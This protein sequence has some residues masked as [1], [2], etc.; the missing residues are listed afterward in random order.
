MD[1]K[2]PFE[3]ALQGNQPQ[4]TGEHKPPKKFEELVSPGPSE[5]QQ[6]EASL[7]EKASGLFNKFASKVGSLL[8]P[9]KEEEKG[10]SSPSKRAKDKMFVIDE[11]TASL[12]TNENTSPTRDKLKKG[13][14][15]DMNSALLLIPF[16]DD[17]MFSMFT[18][19]RDEMKALVYK[20]G[21]VY[22]AGGGYDLSVGED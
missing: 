10:T 22:N 5:P 3:D 8:D 7:G 15:I 4:D 19:V 2:D 11:E 17:T 20:W 18:K 13:N 14:F 21:A 9:R 12:R 6:K 1:I 16:Q